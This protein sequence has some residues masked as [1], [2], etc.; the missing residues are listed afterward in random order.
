MPFSQHAAVLLVTAA[1]VESLVAHVSCAGAEECPQNDDVLLLPV[2]ARYASEI[3]ADFNGLFCETTSDCLAEL[4]QHREASV[5]IRAAWEAAKRALVN[6]KDADT[7]A[8]RRAA[9]ER[10]L[11]FLE[12]RLHLALPRSWEQ[13]MRAAHLG[14]YRHIGFRGTSVPPTF[15]R[16]LSIWLSPGL[17]VKRGDPCKLIVGSKVVSL[18]RSTFDKL[19]DRGEIVLKA[20][21]VGEKCYLVA[22]GG[23][24]QLSDVLRINGSTG[25]VIWSANAWGTG[26]V[27][28]TGRGEPTYNVELLEDSGTVYLLG[29]GSAGGVI[30][31]YDVTSGA[32]VLRFATTDWR[33]PDRKTQEAEEKQEHRRKEKEEKLPCGNW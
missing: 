7:D 14:G 19:M 10:F 21:V 24:G 1:L 13:S 28:W 31:G 25:E 6:S 23:M 20:F 8:P 18:N 11:G 27:V 33:Q 2:K 15:S 5:A 17:R 32:V 16:E 4:K 30:E 22:F 29:S 12:G 9:V 3:A 26:W